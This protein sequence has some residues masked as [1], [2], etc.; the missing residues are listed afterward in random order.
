[1]GLQ[2]YVLVPVC[3]SLCVCESGSVS[4]WKG[5]C[6]EVCLFVYGGGVLC[7]NVPVHVSM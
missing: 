7:V 1:M 3:V 4:V 2:V 5:G 6:V